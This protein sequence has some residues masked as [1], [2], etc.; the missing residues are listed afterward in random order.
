MGALV[1][2][3]AQVIEP[4]LERPFAFFG[5]SMG[6]VVAF[7]LARELRGRGRPQPTLLI[8]SA[9]RAP[10]YRR[11]HVPPPPPT[12]EELVAELRR[13]EGI[14]KEVLED[15]LLM[16]AILPALEADATLYRNYFYTEGEPLACPVRAYGGCADP[17][18][19][20]EHL[21]AWSQQTTASFAIRLFPG[22][23]FYLHP[24]RAELLAALEEDLSA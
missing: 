15:P 24:C 21:E 14:P 8:A 20:R 11:H 5:H 12:G 19:R 22:G 13:L 1:A 9:A 17:N 16:S 18:V 2:A 4:Y 6:A 3:L 10:Q 23:H 7:E